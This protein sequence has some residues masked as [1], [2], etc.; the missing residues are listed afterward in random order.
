MLRSKVS[1]E[2]RI[3]ITWDK[4]EELDEYIGKLQ[5]AAEKL[6]K[7]NRRLRKQHTLICDKVRTLPL[8]ADL[9]VSLQTWVCLYAVPIAAYYFQLHAATLCLNSK[10]NRDA[11]SKFPSHINDDTGFR[12]KIIF[13]KFSFQGTVADVSR[14]STT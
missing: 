11:V 4:A 9:L 13:W 8:F 14:V 6:T 1:G 12:G 7:E 5:A 10:W 3:H 2:G